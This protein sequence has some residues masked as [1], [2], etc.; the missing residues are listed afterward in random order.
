MGVVCAGSRT[1]RRVNDLADA[2]HAL[3]TAQENLT[4]A[5]RA[6]LAPDPVTGRAEHGRIGRT[7]HLTGW[8]EQRVK[9]LANPALADR[10]RARKHT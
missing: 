4:T 8:G 5:L 2:V 1:S 9:E 10:R 7:A 6:Y 3:H